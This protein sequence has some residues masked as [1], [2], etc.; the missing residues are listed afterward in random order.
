MKRYFLKKEILNLKCGAKADGTAR[1]ASDIV[2]DKKE[3]YWS[4]QGHMGRC[5]QYMLAH[6]YMPDS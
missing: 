5:N 2:F 4:D 1:D 6:S 3:K